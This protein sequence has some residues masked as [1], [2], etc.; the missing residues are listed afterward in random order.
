M[1]RSLIGVVPPEI[2]SRRTKQLGGR[3]AM[4]ALDRHWR[5]L[6]SVFETPLTAALG[7]VNNTALL[8]AACDAKNGKSVH[9]VY[10]FRAISLELWLR[11]VVSNGLVNIAESLIANASRPDCT[12]SMAAPN[13]LPKAS[14][15]GALE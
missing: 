4:V 9:M 11:N 1:R 5:E 3:T 14:A 13:S 7:Y 6:Q 12:T 10:M 15:S 2:L 8:R